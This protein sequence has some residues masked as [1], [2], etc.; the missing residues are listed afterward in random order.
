MAKIFVA[1]PQHQ[2]R[3]QVVDALAGHTIFGNEPTHSA[4]VDAMNSADLCILVLPSGPVAHTEAGYMR[5]EEKA[6]FV[7]DSSGHEALPIHQ[8]FDLV[9]SD[10]DVLRQAVA[11]EFAKT[12]PL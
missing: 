12:K 10:I 1:S 2:W 7:Y 3:Q 11:E 6:V 5:G 9:T 4:C 8:L